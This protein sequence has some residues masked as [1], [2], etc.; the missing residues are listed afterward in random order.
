MA[1]KASE[2][3]P[4]VVSREVLEHVLGGMNYAMREVLVLRYVEEL[5]VPEIAEQLGL[6]LSAAKMRLARARSEF[7]SACKELA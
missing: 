7:L 6:G 3:E 1:P 4:G 2:T 5:S